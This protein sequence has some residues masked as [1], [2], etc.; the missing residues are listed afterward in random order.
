MDSEGGQG[1][2]WTVQPVA[3]ERERERTGSYLNYK[4]NE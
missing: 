2:T 1:T 4:I 3:R